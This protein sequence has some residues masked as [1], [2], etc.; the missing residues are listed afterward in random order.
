MRWRV[1]SKWTERL[2]I[3]ALLALALVARLLPGKRIVDDAYI[4]F[5]Y[6]R[7]IAE[8]H[9]FVY[10]P[11]QRV[12][13]TTTPLYTSLLAGLALVTGSRDF[14]TL[15]TLLNA[16]AGG[17][18]IALLYAVGKRVTD[19]WAPAAAAASLW[20]IA[21]YS[22][23]FA[24]GGMETD[25]TIALLLA[26][27]YA[28]V[29]DSSRCMAV[30]SALAVL[31]RPDTVILL[32]PLWLAHILE[33]RRFPWLEAAIA[34]GMLAPWLIFGALTF[35]SPVP[36]SLAAKSITYRLSAGED[37]IRLVQHYSTPFFGHRVLGSG[38]QLIGFAV[39]LLLYCLGGMRAMQRDRRIWPLLVY[40]AG[41]SLHRCRSTSCSSSPASG[42]WLKT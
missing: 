14:P 12:L 1:E 24:I 6:A 30:L 23:T 20:A 35:G 5:R 3:G 16:L 8:G 25:L 33:Q 7:N 38:W 41:T 2:L 42:R 26:A 40:S 27:C 28:H 37:L 36:S 4:T 19:H 31:T 11:G 13:G 17:V 32:G 21:P 34:L 22:V 18:S 39:Y 10:N 9:G 29:T 15:A